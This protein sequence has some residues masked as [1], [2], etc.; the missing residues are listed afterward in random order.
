MSKP[1]W[2]FDRLCPLSMLGRTLVCLDSILIFCASLCPS[3]PDHCNF[4]YTESVA[5]SFGC[6]WVRPPSWWS[7][8]DSA[9]TT[10]HRYL[11]CIGCSMVLPGDLFLVLVSAFFVCLP[12]TYPF[13]SGGRSNVLRLV[14]NDHPSTSERV[15]AST[16]AGGL[17]G[18][19][20]AWILSKTSELQGWWGV[21]SDRV[22]RESN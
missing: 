2:Y 4:G 20:T 8:R 17:A 9:L 7:F 16:F 11:P 19:G 18:G 14:Y 1:Y 15:Y 5:H 3:V 6:R 22:I 13:N 12:N 21:L 10:P